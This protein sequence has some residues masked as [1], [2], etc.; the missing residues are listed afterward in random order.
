VDR[1]GDQRYRYLIGTVGWKRL[2]LDQKIQGRK[3]GEARPKITACQCYITLSP[4]NTP[5][6]NSPFDMYGKVKKLSRES[7]IK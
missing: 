7:T 3:T 5:V 1:C 6:T 2:S 4:Y